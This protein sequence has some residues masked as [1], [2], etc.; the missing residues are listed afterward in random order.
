MFGRWRFYLV[1]NKTERR[2]IQWLIHYGLLEHL[3]KLFLKVII[4]EVIYYLKFETGHVIL[5]LL[6][7]QNNHFI[8]LRGIPVEKVKVILDKGFD[9][10]FHYS[11][12]QFLWKRV[13]TMFLLEMENY[14]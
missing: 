5:A 12:N 3:P 13:Y 6:E 7:I 2:L 9:E 8:D 4:L 11:Y 10:Y 1:S 14:V